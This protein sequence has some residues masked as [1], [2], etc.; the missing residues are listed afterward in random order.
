YLRHQGCAAKDLEQD[1]LQLVIGHEVAHLAKR[2]MSKQLQQRL[3]GTEQGVG[4]FKGLLGVNR[5][6]GQ[7]A[8]TAKRIVDR[9][10]CSFA[11]YEQDQESQADACSARAM[12]EAGG[13]PIAAWEEYLRVRGTVAANE[14]KT[15]DRRRAACFA[16]LASHP[17]DRARENQLRHAA[18]HHRAKMGR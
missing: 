12:I 13:D 3:M 1:A 18:S 8:N 7:Q 10:Q 17:E 9:L 4:L 11:K 14:P 16:A 6:A 15:Q 2:H 5:D